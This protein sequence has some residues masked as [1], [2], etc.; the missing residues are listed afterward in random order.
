MA[1][2]TKEQHQLY[3]MISTLDFRSRDNWVLTIIVLG[4]GLNFWQHFKGNKFCKLTAFNPK[5][6]RYSCSVL[7]AV[8]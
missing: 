3:L 2:N 8:I 4:E 6:M 7:H 5:I 1:S